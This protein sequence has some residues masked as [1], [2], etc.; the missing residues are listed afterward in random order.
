MEQDQFLQQRQA[1][2]V[3][4]PVKWMIY[5]IVTSI[6][7]I[8]TI[9]LLI[10]AFSNDGRLTRQNWAKGMLLFYVVMIILS[11]IIF[12]IFGAGIMALAAANESAY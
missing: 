8:G 6:P 3:I 5:F 4:T 11:I 9:M 10:W 7:V 12:V 1:E 2:P